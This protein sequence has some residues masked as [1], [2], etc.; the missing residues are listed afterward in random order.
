LTASLLDRSWSSAAL[1]IE[2]LRRLPVSL[3]LRAAAF[4]GLLGSDPLGSDP[5]T[6]ILL[7]PANNCSGS[8]PLLGGPR[9]SKRQPLA[10]GARHSVLWSSAPDR[11]GRSDARPA[12]FCS[13]RPGKLTSLVP[14][15]L[16]NSTIGARCLFGPSCAHSRRRSAQPGLT[17]RA[18]ASQPTPVG[19][20]HCTKP[21]RPSAFGSATWLS[22]LCSSY[23]A[24]PTWLRPL[25]SA[26]M[27]SSSGAAPCPA[28]GRSVLRSTAPLLEALGRPVRA[29]LVLGRVGA[30]FAPPGARPLTRLQS[31][32]SGPCPLLSCDHRPLRISAASV[33]GRSVPRLLCAC[34][35]AF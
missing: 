28:L 22:P 15:A 5:L 20:R 21:A 33:L 23:S 30:R 24:Q 35:Y 10:L 2:V 12:R 4:I 17:V 27:I 19:Q 16:N 18:G 26:H 31:L 7:A 11:F 8:L 9:P 3:V 25:S 34:C 14:P 1:V 13:P 6:R 32:R 29:S